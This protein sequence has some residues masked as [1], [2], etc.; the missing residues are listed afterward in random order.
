MPIIN[1]W[2]FT[3]TI[4][5]WDKFADATYNHYRVVSVR[6]FVDKKGLLSDGYLLTLMVLQDDYDYGMDKKNQPR[7]NNQYQNFEVT[8][9]S[10]TYNV[11]KG[12]DIR[13]LDF[14]EEH[15]FVVGFD[16]ILRF[17]DFEIISN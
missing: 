11:K 6:P 13:L 4:I 3:R 16:L 7:E 17:K 8:V 9:L 12:D 5:D 10:R 15:S 14:D 2:C 1:N